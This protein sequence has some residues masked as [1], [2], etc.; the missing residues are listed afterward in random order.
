[1]GAALQ[2]EIMMS[3]KAAGKMATS[4]PM[5]PNTKLISPLERLVARL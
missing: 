1:M 2:I 3:K 5:H 4:K